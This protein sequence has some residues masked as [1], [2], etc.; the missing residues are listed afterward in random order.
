[1][2]NESKFWILIN[3]IVAA[4][5]SV[6]ILSITAYSMHKNSKLSEIIRGGTN[7]IAANCALNDDYGKAPSCVIIARKAEVTP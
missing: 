3:A 4:A 6:L 7:P 1:M 2:D 5:V